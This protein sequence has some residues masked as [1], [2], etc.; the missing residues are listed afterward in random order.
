MQILNLKLDNFRNY[1]HVEI[2]FLSGKNILIGKN[3]MG[4]TNL[5]EAIYTL[6]L[7]KSFRGSVESIVIKKG[8]D[9]ARIEGQIKDDFKTKYSVIISNQG[10]KVKINN[11]NQDKIS[12]YISLINIIL[13]NPDDLK[14]IK[15]SPI[16]RRRFLN[17]EISQLDNS[18]L[19][20][21]NDYNRLLKQRNSYLRTMYLNNNASKE[22]M[23]AITEK[24]VALGEKIFEKRKSFIDKINTLIVDLYFQITKEKGLTV[25]YESDFES[26]NLKN[27]L[28]KYAKTLNKDMSLGMTQIGIHRDDFYFEINNNNIKEYGSE[29]QQKNALLA[30]K[31]AELE[32]FKNQKG[33]YPILILDDLFSEIDDEKINNL[34]NLLPFDSQIFITA[35]DLKKVKKNLLKDSK[36]IKVNNGKL[37]E[38]IYGK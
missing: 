21:V 16:N 8:E 24:L 34:I 11:K 3:G 18:Y 29:G 14:I 9:T 31:L 27:I 37:E 22:Y 12:K 10:K 1:S 2:K 13:F 28:K 36:I 17:I 25:I 35:T 19:I 32:I 30:F 6:A 20:L 15:L 33:S 23:D 26:I 5:I 38:K 7:T 4:K